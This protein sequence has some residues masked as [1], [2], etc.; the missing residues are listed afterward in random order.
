M[1]FSFFCKLST[2]GLIGLLLAGCGRSGDSV[3]VNSDEYTE[4]VAAFY[5]GLAALQVGE[6]RRAEEKLLRVTELYPSEPAAWANLG[7][8]A[9]RRNEID[10]A[11][12]RL[13]EA[14]E[15]AP[16]YSHI[17]Y[18]IGLLAVSRGSTDE[19]IR[20]FRAAVDLDSTNVKATYALVEQL[21]QRGIEEDRSEIRRLVDSILTIDPTNLAVLIES[22]RFAAVDGDTLALSTTLDSLLS[23]SGGWPEPARELLA[24]AVEATDD[25]RLDDVV[26]QVSFLSN[27]LKIEPDYRESL[28]T[29]RTEADQTSELISEFLRLPAPVSRPAPPDDS[30]SFAEERLF[31][32]R[33][34]VDWRWA[35]AVTLSEEGLPVVIAASADTL[36]F[37]DETTVPLTEQVSARGLVPFDFN[38]DFRVDFGIAGPDGFRLLRQ[39]AD[40][41]FVDV[42][43]ELGLPNGI[44]Q[45]PYVAVWTADIDMEGDLDLVL[46]TADGPPMVLRNNGDETFSEWPI[47]EEIRGLRDFVWADLDGDGDPDAGIVEASGRIAV[48]ENRRSRGYHIVDAGEGGAA[49]TAADLNSDGILELVVLYRDGVIGRLQQA[50]GADPQETAELVMWDGAFSDSLDD[51]AFDALS[52]I[53]AMD[54]DNNGAL[55]LISSKSGGTAIWLSDG[56][57]NYSRLAAAARAATFTMADV[58]GGGR[59]DLIGLSADGS[60]VRLGNRGTKNYHSKS[61]RPRAA[62]AVGDQRINPF[63]LGGEIEVRAGTLFQKQAVTDPVV[64]FGIGEN[65]L[66]DVAR[67][68]W[69]NGDVQ[70]EFELLSD[71]TVQARQR[72]KG[73]CPWLFTFDGERMRFVTDFIWRSPLGLRIN[74]QET[75]GVMM[76]ED[77]VKIEGSELK[78]RG[79]V[80]DVRVTAELWETHFFDHVSLMAVDHPEGTEVFV[81]ERFAFPPPDLELKATGPLQPVERVVTGTGTEVTD[82]VRARDEDYLAEFEQGPYQGIAEEHSLVVE[83]GD[84]STDSIYLIAEGWIRPTDSSINVAIS[85]GDH[86]PPQGIR[87]DVPDGR[88]DWSVLYEN[89]GFPAGKHKTIV[90]DL[91]D[92]LLEGVER[93]IRLTTNLEIYWDA[94]HWAGALPDT[95][96]RSVRTDPS[97]ADLRYRGFSVVSEQERS[98]PEIPTYHSLR[99]AAQI[100]QDLEG[101]YTRFGD[102]REL[103]TDVDDRY[104]IMNAGDELA[105]EFEALP[106]PPDGWVRDF[107][108]IGDGWVKDGDYNTLFSETVRPLPSHG[109]PEY[110]TPP[111]LL[112]DDPVYQEHADDWRRFHTRYVAPQ[113]VRS[114]MRF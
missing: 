12:D 43:S 44:V 76:T 21:E 58:T 113:S 77:W 51:E 35:R 36:Y 93:K 11:E 28:A 53:Y 45:R 68:I 23:Q 95:E 100:W 73:S 107:V 20:R 19:A 79:G 83:L 17:R 1:V 99:G 8:L 75:A 105:F 41:S 102:V 97:R 18:L 94:I 29:I 39:N 59:L 81:D 87:L 111:G 47:F 52:R 5:T 26:T 10:L 33:T 84:P 24:S 66:V 25:G 16:E 54:I 104:V 32:Q 88:G 40:S 48:V 22:A 106:D 109:D 96:L 82:L 42:T 90:V 62:D 7:L 9:L 92:G 14:Q 74:A 27:V 6:D 30:L 31:H 67:I 38:Y 69:P 55:D 3:Q 61:I 65:L 112:Q 72:L 78:P 110:S 108:L 46:A 70:A 86:P 15:L 64:H 4:A 49:L 34:D 71:E 63:G 114:A 80:Y 57:G 98:R 50:V 37:E 89:L 60:P 56:D 13:E 2:I 85:Q 91:S 103:L 101:Y